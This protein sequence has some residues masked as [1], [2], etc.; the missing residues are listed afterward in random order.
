MFKKSATHSQGDLFSGVPSILEGKSL[1][2][3]NNSEGWHN[4]FRKQIVSRID[5]SIFIV[6]Y[7][8]KMGAPNSPVS[9]LVGMMVLKDAFCWSDLQ[10]F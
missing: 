9:L 6:L 10:L 5:E 7:S 4:Q 1:N 8:K 3:Y 2:Q